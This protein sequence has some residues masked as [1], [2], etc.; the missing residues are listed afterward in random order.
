MQL[1]RYLYPKDLVK[2]S[3]LWAILDQQVDETLFWGY[4]LYYS[5]FRT[6]IFDFIISIFVMYFKEKYPQIRP[7]LCRQLEK[8]Y[9]QERDTTK[10][11]MNH[12]LIVGSILRNFASRTVSLTAILRY[13]TG[14]DYVEPEIDDT[15]EDE[16]LLPDLTPPEIKIYKTVYELPAWNTIRN[17]TRFPI[18]TTYCKILTTEKLA[19]AGSDVYEMSVRVLEKPESISMEDMCNHWLYYASNSPIWLNRILQHHGTICHETRRIVFTDDAVNEAEVSD[20]EEF[21]HKY[22]YEIDEQTHEFRARLFGKS[23][24]TISLNYFFHNYG[25]NSVYQDIQVTIRRPR[26]SPEKLD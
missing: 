19:D 14:I 23:Y 1:T 10:K 11:Y 25:R 13:R 18:R 8:W 16:L 6:E 5:G 20:E 3:L 9:S 24:T 12:D 4:E 17:V 22:N 15:T 21:Y 7:Y 26:T 2:A